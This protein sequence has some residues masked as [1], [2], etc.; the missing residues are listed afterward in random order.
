LLFFAYKKMGIIN[1]GYGRDTTK[2]FAS[3]SHRP[4][5]TCVNRWSG[6]WIWIEQL[7]HLLTWFSVKI[8]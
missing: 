6:I 3:K 1:L 5:S 2:I 4:V 8:G 7:T